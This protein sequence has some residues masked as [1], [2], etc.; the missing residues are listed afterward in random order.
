MRIALIAHANAPWTAHYSRV[1][2]ARRHEVLLISFHPDEV[3]GVRQVFV[4]IPGDPLLKAK[5]VYVTHVP[6]VRALLKTFSPD[7]VF[8][9]YLVSNGLTAVL[10]FRGPVVVSA[11]GGDLVA[12][13]GRLPAAP[14][15]HRRLVRFICRRARLVHAVS[16]ELAEALIACGVDGRRI[17]TFPVGIDPHLFTPGDRF[18]GGSAVPRLVCTRRQDSVYHNDVVVEALAKLRSE[19]RSFA[20]TFVGG[21]PLLDERRSHVARLGLEDRVRFTGQVAHGD[22]ADLL[23]S[24]ELY[25]SASSADGT[26]S[27]LLEAMACGLFPVVSDIRANRAWIRDGETGFLFETGNARD[28]AAKLARALEERTLWPAARA[29][30]RRLVEQ[31]GDMTRTMERLLDLLEGVV[32]GDSRFEGAAS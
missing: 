1:F 23:R 31:R 20:M 27:S 11:R 22:L 19:G 30:N 7:L 18:A 16:E 28:L 25:I 12:H 24:A 15:V 29:A 26:S 17:V 21:G 14:W 3:P 9:P 8:A 13:L 6:R 32:Q 10:S 5:R 2:Q 4:G